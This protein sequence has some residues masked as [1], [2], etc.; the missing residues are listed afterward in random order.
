M[1]NAAQDSMVEALEPADASRVA[2]GSRL[3]LGTLTLYGSGSMVSD[4]MAFGLSTLLLFYLTIVCGMSGSAAGIALGLT[5]VVDSCIDPLVGSLSDNSRSRH[6]RRHPFMLAAAIP[7]AIAFGLLFSI[8]ANLSG[9]GLFTYAVAALLAARIGLSFFYVP[10]YALG[11][12]LSDDYRERSTIVASRVLFSVVASIAAAILAYG[13]YMTAKNGGLLNRGAYP[14]FAWTCSGIVLLAA[15][16][17]T[18]GTLGTRSRLH[19]AGPRQGAVLG[20]LGVEVAEVFKNPSFRILFAAVLILFVA[21]GFAGALTLHANNYFW[22]LPPSA[23]L[24]ITLSAAGGV[25]VGVFVAG[26][27]SRVM[28]KRIVSMIG[29]IM[30]GVAQFCPAVMQVAGLIPPNDK[31][32][33]LIIAG[34]LGAI[35][36]S[37]ATI[38]FQSMMADAADEHE[39]LFGA[40]REGLYFAGIT[41]SAKA[42]SGIG[43]LIAGVVLDL[44]HFPHGLDLPGAAHVVISADTIRNLGLSYGPGAAVMT[45]V[46]VITLT[47]YRRGKREHDAVREALAERREAT[48]PAT[49]AAE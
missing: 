25:F 22:R 24:I 16:V 39:Y 32:L 29:L 49:S 48:R 13:V 20:R 44:I 12:E 18:L 10:Y 23:I 2:R 14:A 38:G 19:Q 45:A 33:T 37:A 15:A 36:G 34:V 3:G 47:A 40:R 27:M 11:A 8:P 31:V 1:T 7:T 35:G 42:S 21:L 9:I 26:L 17:S 4:T 41:F 28:E 30:I 46:S 43:A 5:L 6:G